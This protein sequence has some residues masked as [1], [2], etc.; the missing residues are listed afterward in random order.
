MPHVHR[1]NSKVGLLQTSERRE[2][3]RTPV[4]ILHPKPTE[5]WV[6]VGLL[7]S[8]KQQV[9]A[10]VFLQFCLSDHLL[11]SIVPN[12]FL[13]LVILAHHTEKQKTEHDTETYQHHLTSVPVGSQVCPFLK[14]DGR[15][16]CTADM[17]V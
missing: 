6:I 3:S 1:M 9:H 15:T 11:K 5:G 7:S 14:S 2:S 10:P 16:V 17:R 8:L 4:A 12:V 13:E